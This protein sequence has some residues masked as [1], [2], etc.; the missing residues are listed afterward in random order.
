LPSF[1]ILLASALNQNMKYYKQVKIGDHWSKEVIIPLYS[2][3][4]RPH[5]K[6]FVQ[7]WAPGLKKGAKVLECVQRRATQLVKGLEGM[8][9][10]EWLKT[11]ACL[12]WR[13]GG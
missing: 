5:L 3:L 11:W 9:C 4:V 12:V 7:F 1:V 10:E 13:K 2:A 6:Y 8:S